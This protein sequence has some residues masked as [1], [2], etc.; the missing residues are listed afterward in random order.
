M[1]H[2]TLLILSRDAINIVPIVL[3]LIHG[4]KS[5]QESARK[6]LKMLKS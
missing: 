5:G 3:S 2:L 4:E 1:V 6:S